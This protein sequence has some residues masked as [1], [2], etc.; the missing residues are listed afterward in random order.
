MTLLGKGIALFAA[1]AAAGAAYGQNY[2]TATVPFEF[3]ISGKTLPAGKYSISRMLSHGSTFLAL[4]NS[5]TRQI[6]VALPNSPISRPFGSSS[7]NAKL[8]FRC[9]PNGCALSQMWD[10]GTRGYEFAVPRSWGSPG[11]RIATVF[12]NNKNVD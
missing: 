10:D 5:D 2:L 12:F 6:V 9:G 8:L 7:N 3:K 1:I 11:E 4:E